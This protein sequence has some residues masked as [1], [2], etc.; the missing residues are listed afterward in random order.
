MAQP[1][2]LG[3]ILLVGALGAMGHYSWKGRQVVR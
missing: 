2:H 3:Y 1:L